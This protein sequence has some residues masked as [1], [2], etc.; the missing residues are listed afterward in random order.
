MSDVLH[1]KSRVYKGFGN[2]LKGN[3]NEKRISFYGYYAYRN[4]MVSDEQLMESK[5]LLLNLIS[6]IVKSIIRL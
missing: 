6:I 3:E 2:K 1:I 4:Y 5:S